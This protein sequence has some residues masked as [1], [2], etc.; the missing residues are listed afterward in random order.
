MGNLEPPLTGHVQSQV[1][2]CDAK[3]DKLEQDLLCK[4]NYRVSSEEEGEQEDV[5]ASGQQR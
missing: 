3:R 4:R 1:I 5:S 2:L